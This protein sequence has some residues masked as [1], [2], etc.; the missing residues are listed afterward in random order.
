M[1]I[2][3]MQWAYR[4]G[5]KRGWKVGNRR[6]RN[7]N[8]VGYNA[9]LDF[10]AV[11]RNDV[12]SLIQSDLIKG[13]SFDPVSCDTESTEERKFETYAE[14]LWRERTESGGGVDK[15]CFHMTQVDKGWGYILFNFCPKCGEKL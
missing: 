9:G 6:G 4:L 13:S 15:T 14:Y 10:N 3:D 11:A 1:M 12:E 5:F 7:A 2:R 8:L